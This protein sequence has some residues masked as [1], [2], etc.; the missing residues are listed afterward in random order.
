MNKLAR[1]SLPLLAITASSYVL[2]VSANWQRTTTRRVQET[3]LDRGANLKFDPQS[4]NAVAAQGVSS[5]QALMKNGAWNQ[6][7]TFSI[8]TPGQEFTLE[9]HTKSAGPIPTDMNLA[10]QTPASEVTLWEAPNK[11]DGGMSATGQLS[12]S[13]G[14][15][16]SK[17]KLI[18]AQTYTVFNPN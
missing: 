6:Q 13:S 3:F 7:N 9:L 4:I 8:Q 12:A 2:P 17:V 1:H 15:E 16:A 18:F 14:A 11:L 10:L 5:N